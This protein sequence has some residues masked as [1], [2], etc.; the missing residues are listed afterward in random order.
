MALET[1]SI[2]AVLTSPAS[3]VAGIAIGVVSLLAYLS[4]R[5]RWVVAGDTTSTRARDI[6]VLVLTTSMALLAVLVGGVVLEE[7]D[8][9]ARV[10]QELA[11]RTAQSELLR[12]RIGAQ[13]DAARSMLADR[14]ADRV[15]RQELTQA[16]AELL[17]FAAFQDPRIVQMI[18]LIDQELAIRASAP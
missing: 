5:A 6:A 8:A 2:I 7:R 4:L 9:R 12:A 3:L 17:R 16:R 11:E 14:A 18:T 10:Q 15:S 13:V 1:E